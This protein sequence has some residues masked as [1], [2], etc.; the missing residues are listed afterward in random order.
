ML[1]SF[2]M[3]VVLSFIIGCNYLYAQPSLVH[4]K[5]ENSVL[6]GEIHF[7]FWFWSVYDVKLYS[8][9]KP[10][11][12]DQGFLLE[13]S[14]LRAFSSQAIAKE[15]IQQIQ[16]QHP[17]LK[18]SLLKKW[19]LQLEAIFPNIK[20]GDQLIGYYSPEGYAYFYDKKAQFLGQIDNTKFS[21]YFFD[22][23]LSDKAE[24]SELSRELRG[25]K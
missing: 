25:L 5:S 24:N 1:K 12:F 16:A 8:T 3:S 23:W 2:V 21:Q 7:K 17:N 22:I 6:I 11:K 4:L 20:E 9:K 18:A 15:S 10:F 19:Q 14:Y 13:I